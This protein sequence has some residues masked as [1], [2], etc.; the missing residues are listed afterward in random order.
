MAA[1]CTKLHG[2]KWYG[3]LTMMGNPSDDCINPYKWIQMV[4]EYGYF[5]D[6]IINFSLPLDAFSMI[7]IFPYPS[8][9]IPI[10][11]Y[12]YAYSIPEPQ[13]SDLS[14]SQCDCKRTS[15]KK[16]SLAFLQTCQVR[17]VCRKLG[18]WASAAFA[19]TFAASSQAS[20]W[21]SQPCFL[22]PSPSDSPSSASSSMPLPLGRSAPAPPP[23]GPWASP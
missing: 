16:G 22:S 13:V 23:S 1:I 6:S 14:S 12:P 20:P 5:S 4:V 9:S 11:P 10:H 15:G 2:K 17:V 7:C 21:T 18:N 3:H 8:L 19:L